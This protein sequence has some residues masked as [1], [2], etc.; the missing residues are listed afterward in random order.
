MSRKLAIMGL[1]CVLVA[2]YLLSSETRRPARYIIPGS[3]NNSSPIEQTISPHEHFV[4]EHIPVPGVRPPRSQMS[5]EPLFEVVGET[6]RPSTIDMRTV[7]DLPV[8]K[9]GELPAPQVSV[10]P[11]KM[12]DLRVYPQTA[13]L[14]TPM[15]A[16]QTGAMP[17]G[18][19]KPPSTDTLIVTTDT[20]AP[21]VY[22]PP[23]G[24][25]VG[26]TRANDGMQTLK[27]QP[28]HAPLHACPAAVA[29][30]GAPVPA[31]WHL[32][33]QRLDLQSA[34]NPSTITTA[35]LPSHWQFTTT[36]SRGAV[37]ETGIGRSLAYPSREAVLPSPCDRLRVADRAAPK[38]IREAQ[39]LGMAVAPKGEV[40]SPTSLGYVGGFTKPAQADGFASVRGRALEP[41]RW[42]GEHGCESSHHDVGTVHLGSASLSDMDYTSYRTLV[43]PPADDGSDN[44]LVNF[45]VSRK[46]PSDV[47]RTGLVAVVEQKTPSTSATHV[48]FRKS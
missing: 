47:S 24:R 3:P 8:K 30:T 37:I 15:A 45:S 17:N 44:T 32:G 42:T 14:R 5:H 16:Y 20:L 48:H 34:L 4:P 18:V 7:L 46:V 19:Q 29:C 36:D 13:L 21:P 39:P 35:P 33:E 6:R 38:M 25:T 28:I 26:S 2:A 43:K 9:H 1:V 41:L 11:I 40:I 10:A 27:E 12:G 22:T 31:D 23:G